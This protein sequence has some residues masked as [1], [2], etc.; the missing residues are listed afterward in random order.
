VLRWLRELSEAGDLRPTVCHGIGSS[1]D[2][3]S[4]R[5]IASPSQC[6]RDPGL[7]AATVHS[8]L[9]RRGAFDALD[10]IS[11]DKKLRF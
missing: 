11:K 6:R 8:S 3:E 2:W 1:P 10:E 4:R 9:S 7:I 5:T